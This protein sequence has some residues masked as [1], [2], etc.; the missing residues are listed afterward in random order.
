MRSII[1]ILLM[2]FMGASQWAAADGITICRDTSVEWL[3]F[4]VTGLPENPA[5]NT[6]IVFGDGG[7][8]EQSGVWTIDADSATQS[9]QI[10]VWNEATQTY[11]EIDATASAPACGDVTSQGDAPSIRISMSSDCAF[12]ETK[13]YLDGQFTGHWSQ[14]ESNGDPVLLHYGGQLV[15][16][17][18]QS[19]NPDDY[20]A[21]PTACF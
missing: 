18:H 12:I 5:I 21:V 10:Y 16:S 3:R 19:I 7:G 11:D 20:R 14:V 4:Q 1:A 17:H 13:D 6:G 15:G 9:T 8:S 2:V